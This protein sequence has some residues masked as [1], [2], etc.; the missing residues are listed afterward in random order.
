LAPEDFDIHTEKHTFGDFF[1]LCPSFEPTRK[2]GV[3]VCSGALLFCCDKNVACGNSLMTVN[4]Y[5]QVSAKWSRD[6]VLAVLGG[7]CLHDRLRNGS[8]RGT[9]SSSTCGLEAVDLIHQPLTIEF[10][11]GGD[12]EQQPPSPAFQGQAY[13]LCCFSDCLQIPHAKWCLSFCCVFGKPEQI[14]LT[15]VRYQWA[16]LKVSK[17]VA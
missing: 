4:G 13:I 10:N 7:C 9:S 11:A 16:F 3:C 17:L 12:S 6:G 15:R 5:V 1:C 2:F 8:I 14:L